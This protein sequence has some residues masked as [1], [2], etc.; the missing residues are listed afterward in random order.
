VRFNTSKRLALRAAATAHAIDAKRSAV[1]GGES[2]G[3][4][5]AEYRWQ[6][7]RLFGEVRDLVFDGSRRQCDSCWLAIDVSGSAGKH[8][9]AVAM[10]S[11]WVLISSPSPIRRH[12]RSR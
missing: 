8:A 12:E 4:G 9:V 2:D 3:A 1:P 11:I 6:C 10:W 5:H 7:E